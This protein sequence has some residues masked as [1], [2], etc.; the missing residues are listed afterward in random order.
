MFFRSRVNNALAL[1]GV[2]PSVFQNEF[3]QV[4]Q[5][6]GMAVGATPQETALMLAAELPLAFR[7][8]MNPITAKNWI[9]KRKI[10]PRD[11]SVREALWTLG[12][13]ELADY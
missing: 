10:N 11:P 6:A 3:R 9:R 1:L 8:N 4:G 2:N 12:W 5:S 13:Y 7:F